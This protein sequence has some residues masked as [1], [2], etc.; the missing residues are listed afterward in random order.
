MQDTLILKQFIL[1]PDDPLRTT[2]DKRTT[3]KITALGDEGFAALGESS[4]N[5]F[6]LC[7]FL[8]TY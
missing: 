5:Y 1:P 7:K 6:S 4:K 8:R 2:S 3:D